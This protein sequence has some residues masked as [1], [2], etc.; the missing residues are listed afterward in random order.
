MQIPGSFLSYFT[1]V[2]IAERIIISPARVV[3]LQ[4]TTTEI[5]SMWSQIQP[6]VI[7]NKNENF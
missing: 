5:I 2:I 3:L 4:P 6:W 7:D 1:V